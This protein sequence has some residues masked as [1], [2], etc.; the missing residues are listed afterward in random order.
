MMCNQSHSS[1]TAKKNFHVRAKL[2]L[3]IQH[4]SKI[5]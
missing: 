4:K 3:I 2:H 1:V 5:W